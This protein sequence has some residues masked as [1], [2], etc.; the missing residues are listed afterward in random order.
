MRL[1][2]SS[3]TV[4]VRWK[5]AIVATAALSI[6]RAGLPPPETITGK[7]EPRGPGAGGGQR[8]PRRSS[9]AEHGPADV[10]PQPLVVED[11]LADRLGELIALPPALESPRALAF[12]T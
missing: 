7:L 9:A 5:D 6:V 10:V 1:V 8:V 11:E 2:S 12:S 4:Q 3:T